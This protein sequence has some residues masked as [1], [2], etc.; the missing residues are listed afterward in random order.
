[1]SATR[2]G[3]PGNTNATK[4]RPWTDAL[5]KHAKQRGTLDKAAEKI[6]QKAE[7]GDFYAIEELGNRL[8]GKPKATV[9]HTGEG[10]G[11]IRHLLDVIKE[12]PEP[13]GGS[14]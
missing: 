14:E 11:P 8:E 2:G 3:Q 12:L 4:N 6:C 13:D 10:G 7:E 5:R 9:E 1:M